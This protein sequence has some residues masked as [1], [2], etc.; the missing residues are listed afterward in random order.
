MK[1]NS[2]RDLSIHLTVFLNLLII[3]ESSFLKALNQIQI[4]HRRLSGRLLSIE[5]LRIAP[6]GAVGVIHSRNYFLKYLS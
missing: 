5:I 1:N 6:I 2:K 4:G 3:L